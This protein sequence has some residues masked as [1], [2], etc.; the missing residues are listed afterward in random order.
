MW[1]RWRAPT[2]L[3]AL[4]RPLR[5]VLDAAHSTY[6]GDNANILGFSNLSSVGIG[7][8][9]DSSACDTFVTRTRLVARYAFGHNVTGFAIG[10]ALSF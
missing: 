4:E 2:G 8:E 5:Y 7:L 9:L 1:A 3:Y 6:W 10:L